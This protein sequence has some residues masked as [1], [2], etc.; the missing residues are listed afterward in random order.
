M[1]ESTRE[2]ILD[3]HSKGFSQRQI[4]AAI[5]C[6]QKNVWRHLQS[7]KKKDELPGLALSGR[8]E[9]RDEDGNMRM[10]WNK[11]NKDSQE[12]KEQAEAW[13]TGLT[14]EIRPLRKIAA[15]KQVQSD[16]LNMY[17]LTDLHLGMLS[18]APE[19]GA[20]YDINIAKQLV[21][22][23]FQ[24]LIE[25]APKAAVGYFLE[26]GDYTHYDSMESLTPQSKHLLDADGRPGRMIE[27]MMEVSDSIV[28]MMARKYPKVIVYHAEG[29]H[30]PIL[31]QALQAHVAKYYEKVKHVEVIKTASPYHAIA[32]GKTMLGSHHGHLARGAKLQDVIVADYRKMFGETERLEIHTGHLHHESVKEHPLC[33]IH[34]HQTLAARDAYAHRGGFRGG[35]S[36]KRLTYHKE[37]GRVSDGWAVAEMF[38]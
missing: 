31:S 36:M 22:D 28:Q 12:L 23:S 27:A 10:Y 18:W 3:L 9:L 7:A 30:N 35:R 33:M 5:G 4:A 13:L 25:T 17:V 24:Y 26:L 14:S 6:A 29:N 16:L 8:S 1:A 32:W 15:P 11:Y 38:V 37:H 19:T 34:Q 2:R 21:I 20:N